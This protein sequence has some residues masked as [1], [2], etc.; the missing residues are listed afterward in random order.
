[1]R[2]SGCRV[3]ILGLPAFV[4]GMF[5]MSTEVKI[6]WTATDDSGG[7][8]VQANGNGVNPTTIVSGD[9]PPRGRFAILSA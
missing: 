1:M 2:L 4:F 9:F 7:Y 3:A 5:S 6:Y 8:V